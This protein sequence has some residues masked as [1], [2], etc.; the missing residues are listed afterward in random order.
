VIVTYRRH[1]VKGAAAL[2]ERALNLGRLHST[3]WVL[4][5]LLFMPAVCGLE[6]GVLRLTGSVV[7]VPQIAFGEAIFFFAAFFVGAIGEELGWQGYAYPALTNRLDA[8]SSAVLLGALWAFWHVIPFFELGRSVDWIVWH[9]LSAIA[10]RVIIVWLFE[11]T[12]KSLLV[13]VLFHTMINVSLALFPISGSYYDPFVMFAILLVA[14]GLAVFMWGPL[15]LAHYRYGGE[16][17]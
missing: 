15:T 16:D 7:P 1:G 14:V 8:L 10:L 17:K 2:I 6:F 13:A 3:G 4:T 9:S 11:N 5:A 12:G